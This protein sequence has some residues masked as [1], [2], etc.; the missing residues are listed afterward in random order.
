MRTVLT[1]VL[2]VLSKGLR[3]VVRS[4][5][6]Q[7]CTR[8]IR[9]V[10]VLASQNAGLRSRAQRGWGN[11]IRKPT[12]GGNRWK[13]REKD[14]L[15]FQKKFKK[16][17]ML[18][19]WCFI[20]T[21]NFK[22]KHITRCELWK[23]QNQC[24]IV[25]NS[26]VTIQGGIFLFHSSHLVMFFNL[27]FCVAIKHHLLNILHFFRFLWNFKIWFPRSFHWISAFVSE[28]CA[29]WILFVRRISVFKSP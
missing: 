21:Q 1:H 4:G 13:P 28:P 26:N 18:R 2:H 15:K 27:K 16:C 23:R 6:I 14:V 11:I 7:R 25:P 10:W 29:I 8:T 9:G 19:G 20:A 12:F 22:L 3:V 17:G 24:W 5:S